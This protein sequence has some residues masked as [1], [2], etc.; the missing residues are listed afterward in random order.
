[1]MLA[2]GWHHHHHLVECLYPELVLIC[3]TLVF[4]LGLSHARRV[5]QIFWERGWK[6]FGI[7]FYLCLYLSLSL[8][9]SLLMFTCLILAHLAEVHYNLGHKHWTYSSFLQKRWFNALCMFSGLPSS[10]LCG[11][12][13]EGVEVSSVLG[14][15]AF[16][17]ETVDA[18]RGWWK[19]LCWWW[20]WCDD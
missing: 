17:C 1:M 6:Y 20:W 14:L 4:G 12:C 7:S 2:L 19:W 13:V 10:H 11:S 5:A 18:P 9:L 15:Q 16:G 3:A 8:Y